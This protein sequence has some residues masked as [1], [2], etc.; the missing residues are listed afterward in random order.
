MVT[1]RINCNNLIVVIVFATRLFKPK[2]N[3]SIYILL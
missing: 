2:C 1:I 3:I